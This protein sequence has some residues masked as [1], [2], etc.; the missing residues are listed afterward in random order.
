MSDIKRYRI[1]SD[2]AKT[3]HPFWGYSGYMDTVKEARE[4]LVRERTFSKKMELHQVDFDGNF[5]KKVN[6]KPLNQNK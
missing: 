5:I 3:K 6:Y 4:A 2:G 1:Y